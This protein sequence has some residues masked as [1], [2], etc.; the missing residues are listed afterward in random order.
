MAPILDS[1]VSELYRD[2]KSSTNVFLQWPWCQ[3]KLQ[4][5]STKKF[6]STKDIL[7]AAKV[8]KKARS[9]VPKSILSSLRTAITKRKQVLEST[10]SI[11]SSLATAS[12]ISPSSHVNES[13]KSVPTPNAF[14]PLAATVEDVEDDVSEIDILDHTC[15]SNSDC[16]TPSSAPTA[17]D[18]PEESDFVLADDAI[19]QYHD[20]ANFLLELSKVYSQLEGYWRD[21]ANG[22]LPL[23]VA[24]WL[25]SLT[26]HTIAKHTPPTF[27]NLCESV[28]SPCNTC[29]DCPG[30]RA[31]IAGMSPSP[32]AAAENIARGTRIHTIAKAINAYGAELPDM[33]TPSL[34]KVCSD[35]CPCRIRTDGSETELHDQDHGPRLSETDEAHLREILEL[36][37]ADV[38]GTRGITALERIKKYSVEGDRIYQ[39]EPLC[40]FAQALFFS[41]EHV[42]P[43][44]MVF[45]M[46]FFL[47]AAESASVSEGRPSYGNCEAQP[48]RLAM[49]MRSAVD[50][51]IE[52]LRSMNLFADW[53]QTVNYLEQ[54]RDALSALDGECAV[55]KYHGSPWTAGNQLTELL[56]QASLIGTNISW[57]WAIINS[58]LHL[59]N[60][61]RQVGILRVKKIPL[62]DELAEVLI[63]DTF[64]GALPDRNFASTFSRIVFNSGIDRTRGRV[65]YGFGSKPL[66][67][68]HIMWFLH[69]HREAHFEGLDWL[70]EVHGVATC[71]RQRCS[72]CKKDPKKDRGI[73][74][75]HL[76]GTLPEYMEK[77][78]TK[79]LPE[80]EG[81][82]PISRLNFFG[83]FLFCARF[84]R[85]F[86]ELSEA[87]LGKPFRA[88]GSPRE[89]W[90]HPLHLARF[91]TELVLDSIDEGFG[92]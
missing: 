24:A 55:D 49:D 16:E 44:K 27:F 52:F 6:T 7:A 48:R 80:L 70:G 19:R 37:K 88:A 61:M 74:E 84:M 18:E 72:N 29:P 17:P 45:T 1:S 22:T 65:Q 50:P 53:D 57:D 59:Y 20:S 56:T 40:Y 36:I 21:A 5:P 39:S 76:A 78:K 83:L 43:G 33:G 26:A 68:Q 58:T 66:R 85:K 4:D 10:L 79:V 9:V 87:E 82:A 86:G 73:R 60:A 92:S 2:Y 51:V 91:A 25:T 28:S 81:T 54:F 38:L 3:V 30:V 34:I 75:V 35:E 32:A 8:I 15:H 31:F 47:L 77:A 69:Q 90:A 67:G 23:P 11:L 13:E 64:R 46:D 14:A 62:L 71:M 89:L 42:S 63:Q 12:A 41:T